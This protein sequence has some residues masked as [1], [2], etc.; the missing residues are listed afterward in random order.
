MP[1]SHRR[2]QITT[3]DSFCIADHNPAQTPT[4]DHETARQRLSHAVTRIA[5][6]QDR[7]AAGERH[8]MLVVF[9]GMDTAGKDGT[10]DHVFSGVNP[11]G[12]I[13]SS[14]KTPTPAEH[15]H[16]FLWRVHAEAP[17]A[18][19]IAVFN[20][21][22]YE[23]V[24]VTRVHPDLVQR[25]GPAPRP[26]DEDFWHHRLRDI[27][28]FEHMLARQG[29]VV[30]K[31]FLHISKEEQRKR[32][33]ERLQ[34]PG[35]CWKFQATDLTERAHWDSYMQAYEKA[36]AATSTARAPWYVI[37]ADHKWQARMIVAEIVADS[38]EQLNLGVPQPRPD[39]QPIL[40][41]ARRELGVG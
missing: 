31:F 12:V 40:E 19:R 35:K 25:P 6:L 10:I 41:A 1:S 22:H 3:P 7:M 20:R 26:L 2:Y 16:D 23:E 36:I 4:V 38:L 5:A 39:M 11:A 8:S 9:Q 28:H 21:S 24:L 32:I 15:L 13:V 18:G 30:R 37:P 29:T 27:T 14:F 17:P 33:V 34:D